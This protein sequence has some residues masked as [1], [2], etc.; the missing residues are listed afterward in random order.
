MEDNGPCLLANT[1]CSLCHSLE[2]E[3]AWQS[4]PACGPKSSARS[5]RWWLE[6][7]LEGEQEQS[8][9]SLFIAQTTL[10]ERFINQFIV[11]RA[12]FMKWEGEGCVH[13]WV[14]GYIVVRMLTMYFHNIISYIIRI[15]Y[16]Y[17]TPIPMFYTYVLLYTFLICVRT[18]EL[19]VNVLEC[20]DMMYTM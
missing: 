3:W 4:Q 14:C 7:D 1:T 18:W 17:S 12:V 11:S 16:I 13:V 8:K 6:W 10:V 20:I 2:L 19:S 9:Y 5:Q 15:L